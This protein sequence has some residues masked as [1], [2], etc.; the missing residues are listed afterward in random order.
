M[1]SENGSV[2]IPKT[3]PAAS[4]RILRVTRFKERSPMEEIMT[5]SLAPTN[6]LTWPEAMMETITLGN[7]MGRDRMTPQARVV[8]FAPPRA[9]TP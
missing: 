5:I 7:P 4:A 2:A 6:C 1:S 8:P 9:K 3:A